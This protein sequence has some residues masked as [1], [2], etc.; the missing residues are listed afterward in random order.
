MQQ[1]ATIGVDLAKQEFQVHGAEA[2]GSSVVGRKLRRGDVRAFFNRLSL[3]L[4]GVEACSGA[5]YWC[6]RSPR[7]VTICAL[8][9]AI[10]RE[11]IREAR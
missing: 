6:A 11:A 7:S 10:L 5:H 9:S 4:V 8:D 1:I 3:C 2:D